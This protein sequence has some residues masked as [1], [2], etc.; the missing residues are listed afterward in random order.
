MRYAAILQPRLPIPT[1]ANIPTHPHGGNYQKHTRTPSCFLVWIRALAHFGAPCTLFLI[2]GPGALPIGGL[3]G[4]AYYSN[5]NKLKKN[6]NIPSHNKWGIYQLACNTCNLSYVGQTSRSLN[7]RF[8]EYIK[9]T[10]NNN[11]QWAYA[12]HILQNQ[13]ECG[14]M[15]TVMTLL[16]PKITQA[17][18]FLTSNTTSKPFTGKG[19]SFRSKAQEK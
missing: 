12:Q 19:E 9:Y 6:H 18:S 14:Q 2:L 13:H 3:Q 15:N 7:I 8:Q 4:S 10:A 5:L 16:N 11:P 1:A 17:C